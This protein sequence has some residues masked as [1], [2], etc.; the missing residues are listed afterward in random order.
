MLGS[1]K[2][3][4]AALAVAIALTGVFIGLKWLTV[5]ALILWIVAM[6]VFGTGRRK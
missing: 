4:F 2:A 3:W 1:H 6:V 5:V